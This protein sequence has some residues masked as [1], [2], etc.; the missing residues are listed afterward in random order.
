MR[1]QRT[2]Y[3]NEPLILIRLHKE[4]GTH[5]SSNLDYYK[6]EQSQLR[7]GF[8]NALTEE[9]LVSMYGSAYN[10]YH[11]MFCFFKGG[12][13]TKAYQFANH[14][15]QSS[16][17]PDDLTEKLLYLKGFIKELTNGQTRKISIFCAGEY[18]IRLYEELRSKLITVDSFSDNNPGKWGYLFDNITCISPEELEKEKDNTLIIVATRIP[19]E[20]VKQLKSAGFPYVTTKQ[21]IDKVLFNVPPVKWVNSLND[22]EGIDYSSNDVMLLINKFNQTVFDICNYY[23][24]RSS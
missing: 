14:K 23:E 15:F 10:F 16:S 21:E 2:L 12:N 19:T 8:I 9:E 6:S 18:G 24:G 1:Y 22:I 11:K 20:I 5:T 3:I 13:M 17:I 4:Q 7:V